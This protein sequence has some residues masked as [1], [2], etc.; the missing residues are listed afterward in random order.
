MITL[1]FDFIYNT[2]GAKPWSDSAYAGR[3][4]VP[5]SPTRLLRTIAAGMFQHLDSLGMRPLSQPWMVVEKQLKRKV[6]YERKQRVDVENDT[7]IQIPEEWVNL[8]NKLSSTLPSYYIPP[9]TCSGSKTYVPKQKPDGAMNKGEERLR[10]LYDAF[11][12]FDSQDSS[13]FVQYDIELSD[14]EK[15]LLEI[16]LDNVDYLGRSEYACDSSLVSSLPDGLTINC[17]P[18]SEGLTPSHAPNPEFPDCVDWLLKSTKEVRMLGYPRNPAIQ[19]V[20]YTLIPAEPKRETPVS[21]KASHTAIFDFASKEPIS[22]RDGLAWTDKLHKTLVSLCDTSTKFTGYRDGVVAEENERC[23]YFWNQDIN[24]RITTLQ[25]SSEEP[26]TPQEQ[27][28]M[29]KVQRLYGVEG[30]V[31]V[32]LLGFKKEFSPPATRFKTAT[33]LLLYTSPREGRVHRSPQAQAINTLYWS[34]NGNTEKLS[35]FEVDGD[36]VSAEVPGVGR[37]SARLTRVVHHINPRRG[38][39]VAPL[40]VGF[41]MVIE[42]ENPVSIPAVGFN[43]RFGSGRLV[44]A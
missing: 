13:V 15:S 22:G 34:V 14:E 6:K 44:P 11:I 17:F 30:E 9:F 33:P 24:G 35:E 37:V 43:R 7:N 1:E 8:L 19:F 20:N 27:E 25:V 3:V 4:E 40:P 38:N 2:Y 5:P 41:E 18:D 39:R 12:V 36:E 32:R 42:T 29:K 21:R 23:W 10:A 26:F 28:A 16:A 31:S